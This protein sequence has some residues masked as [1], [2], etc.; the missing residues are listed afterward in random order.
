MKYA[1]AT[2]R[3]KKTSEGAPT[4]GPLTNRKLSQSALDKAIARECPDQAL[5]RRT[6]D[7]PTASA[8]DIGWAA[9]TTSRKDDIYAINGTEHKAIA[10]GAYFRLHPYATGIR[11]SCVS[12]GSGGPTLAGDPQ[13]RHGQANRGWILLGNRVCR[14]VVA[15][16]NR[17]K[18]PQIVVTLLLP[19]ALPARPRSPRSSAA[20]P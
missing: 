10:E 17:T 13:H 14:A 5:F 4:R 7:L 20:S 16:R 18:V 2:F 11:G 15:N 1:R 3:Y 6:R 12:A 9:T 8:A 19:L